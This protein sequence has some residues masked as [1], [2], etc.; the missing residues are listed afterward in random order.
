MVKELKKKNNMSV[1]TAASAAAAGGSTTGGSTG[2]WME[3]MQAKAKA[4]AKAGGGDGAHTHG[5]APTTFKSSPAKNMKTGDYSQGFEGGVGGYKS[6]EM[7]AKGH[8]NSPIEKNFGTPLQRGIATSKG[9]SGGE[10]GKPQAKTG[11]GSGLN[12][13][14]VGSSPAKGFWDKVKSIGKK[15]LD[16]LGLKKK[17]DKVLG[18]NQKAEAPAAGEG[19]GGGGD[20]AHTHGADGGVVADTAV[21]EPVETAEQ[22]AVV[23]DPIDVVSGAAGTAGA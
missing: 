11:V 10:P 18:I 1:S 13:A 14:A 9:L 22:Q 19:G 4:K 21:A 15:A 7:K 8:N 3:K 20:G 17:A 2:G 12:F 16:P 6:F 5:A 23:H